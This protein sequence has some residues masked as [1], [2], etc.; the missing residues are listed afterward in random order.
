[1]PGYA[2][3]KDSRYCRQIVMDGRVGVESKFEENREECEGDVKPRENLI[4]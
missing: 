2:C 1:M 3:E 4:F